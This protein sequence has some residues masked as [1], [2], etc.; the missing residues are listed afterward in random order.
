MSRSDTLDNFRRLKY[1]SIKKHAL[2]G[3]MP[4]VF[5][6]VSVLSGAA[7]PARSSGSW[8]AVP[9]LK[10]GKRLGTGCWRQFE[11]HRSL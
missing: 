1:I 7:D 4:Y 3:C 10:S 6:F 9:A 5:L 2:G 8:E 11:D